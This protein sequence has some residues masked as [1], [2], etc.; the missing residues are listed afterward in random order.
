MVRILAVR[1]DAVE[2]SGR[3]LAA[4][5][6]LAIQRADNKKLREVPLRRAVA[7][8]IK[9]SQLPEPARHRRDHVVGR[10]WVGYGRCAVGGMVAATRN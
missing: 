8:I 6:H 7:H 3:K 10:A 5:V 4:L 9:H 1:T 2:G